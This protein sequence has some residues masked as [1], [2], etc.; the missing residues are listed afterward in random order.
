MIKSSLYTI[1]S[2]IFI[3]ASVLIVFW[4]IQQESRRDK[5]K[6][7]SHIIL[8]EAND[9][10]KNISNQTDITDYDKKDISSALLEIDNLV[11]AVDK[12]EVPE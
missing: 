5:T 8:N 1:F 9:D 11:N 7:E 10:E 4:I 2:I 3:S 12:T 6:Q